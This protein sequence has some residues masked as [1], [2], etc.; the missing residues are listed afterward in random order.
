MNQPL[1]QIVEELD[2]RLDQLRQERDEA[3]LHLTADREKARRLEHDAK[4]QARQL[5]EASDTAM[6]VAAR[7]L[8]KIQQARDTLFMMLKEQ[9]DHS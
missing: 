4:Q 6:V 9:E 8:E 3:R 2:K 1:Q 7:K 5:R